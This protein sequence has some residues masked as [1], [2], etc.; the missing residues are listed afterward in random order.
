MRNGE[1]KMEDSAAHSDSGVETALLSDIGLR[2]NNNQD[3][4]AMVL[5][6]DEASWRKQGHLFVVAD[7]MGAHAAGELASKLAA[8]NISLNYPKFL[9]ESPPV[10]LRKAIKKANDT[11]HDRGQANAEFT[12]MGTTLTALLLLP[13]GAVVGH[14]GDSRAYRLRGNRFEQL[15]FDHSLVWE[16]MQS[17]KVR[18]EDVPSFVPR[19]VITRSL[20]PNSA[21]AIDLEGPFPLE[22]GD[23]FLLCSDGLSGQVK[24][25]EIGVILGTL[26]PQE[27][28]RLLI[29][30]ANLRGG[31][32]NITAMVVRVSD[33]R[34][35]RDPGEPWDIP[36][37]DDAPATD[38]SISLASW[39]VLFVLLF[40]TVVLALSGNLM[41][42]ACT[43]AA[44]ILA[45][46]YVLRHKLTTAT[47]YTT[48][49]S[50][51]RLGRGPYREFAC[52]PNR[53]FADRLAKTV[54]E[55]NEAAKDESWKIDW[56]VFN[57]ARQRGTEATQQQRFE[58]AIREYS[59]AII[60]MMAELRKQS[61]L[62]D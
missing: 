40:L 61:H 54:E 46:L 44:T 59:Q 19:N 13:Q 32:D 14:V 62:H 7:G 8:D 41:A 12:G 17:G 60:F 9:S 16:M 52:S 22:L 58:E 2:R 50:G 30:L 27:A 24:D 42:A 3:S 1:S 57:T 49:G 31:P 35:T 47:G 33:E 5:A 36:S 6:P 48:L 25:D 11:I 45:T 39:I 53:T 51:P 29:D 15:S 38:R 21:V 18:E 56:D 23:T 55:L 10:A 26:P 20:G 43:T 34:L 37:T 4:M 28:V